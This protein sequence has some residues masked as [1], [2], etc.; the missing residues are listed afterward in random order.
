[1]LDLPNSLIYKVEASEI[2]KT[3]TLDD[4]YNSEHSIALYMRKVDDL[5][6]L[7]IVDYVGLSQEI[8]ENNNVKK[9]V[10][11]VHKRG[12]KLIAF[13]IHTQARYRQCSNLLMD[14]YCGDFLYIP[15]FDESIISANKINLLNLVNQLQDEDVSFQEVSDIINNDPA[16]SYE[17]LRVAN[18]AAFSSSKRIESIQQAVVRMG[19]LNLKNLVM[20]IAMKNV[21]DKPIELIESGLIR[22]YMCKKIADLKD[23]E[24]SEMFYTAGLLSIIDTML[25]KPMNV[26]LQK[27]SLSEE[28]SEALINKKGCVG[29]ILSQVIFY[30]QGHWD[31]IGDAQE[32]SIDLCEVYIESMTLASQTIKV[33]KV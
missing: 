1:M 21:S 25:D 31:A 11:Y 17:L 23:Y 16:L 6:Y 24:N 8:I 30:E 18:S 19:F 10:N 32:V 2:G 12:H 27:T 7:N 26:L 15:D 4:I 29:E 5:A 22:A 28:V 33:M 20:T 13:D 3:Y 9:V 14:Y